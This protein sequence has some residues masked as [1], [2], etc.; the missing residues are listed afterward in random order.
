MTKNTQTLLTILAAMLSSSTAAQDRIYILAGQS[1]MMGLAHTKNLAPAYKTTP[2]N[3][4]FFYKCGAK[5][6]MLKINT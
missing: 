2:S 1:N 4:S 6:R 3:V 5:F